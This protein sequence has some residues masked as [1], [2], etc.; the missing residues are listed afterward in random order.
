[1]TQCHNDMTCS[2]FI[3][4]RCHKRMNARHIKIYSLYLLLIFVSGL[5]ILILQEL[6]LQ[7]PVTNT[8]CFYN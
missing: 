7:I 8:H 1:M 4:T 5:K 2:H 3:R 6:G